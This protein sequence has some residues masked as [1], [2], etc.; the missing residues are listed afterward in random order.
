MREMPFDFAD[1]SLFGNDAGED[2]L[3]QILNSYFVEQPAFAPFLSRAQNFRI[4]RSRKGMGKSALLSK[5]A[6]DLRQLPDP[7]IVVKTTG[8]ELIGIAPP[9][10][11][12]NPLV[13]HN[14]WIGVL[15]ARINYAIGT[16]IGFAFS[17]T[18]MALVE[19]SEI[20]GFKSRNF[21]GALMARIKSSKIPI[22]ITTQEYSNHEEL[23]RRAFSEIPGRQVWLMVD[24]IDATFVNSPDH[25]SLVSSFFSAC[26]SIVPQVEG[27]GIR[28]SVRSDVWTAL[29]KN[30]ALDKCEQYCTE[31]Q[32]SPAE[33]KA[34]LARKILAY[35]ERKGTGHDELA[36]IGGSGLDSAISAVFERL[37]WDRALVPPFRPLQILSAGRPRW[38][39]QLCRLAGM[40]AAMHRRPR[41]GMSEIKAVLPEYSRLRL[42]DI[43][44]E[45]DHRFDRLQQL[46]ETFANG[47]ARYV[48]A[49]L[50]ELIES[51]FL[52][53]LPEPD[54]AEVDGQRLHSPLQLAHFLYKTGFLVGRVASGQPSRGSSEFV[55]YE[56]R[57]ELLDDKRNL[58]DGLDW[59]IHPSYREA[60][61]IGRRQAA[62]HPP[63][64][65]ML[66]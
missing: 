51:E 34:V 16:E 14:Y 30:E 23:F 39:S 27:L 25:N 57:P 11:S 20:A 35:L 29:R 21:V 22:E 62:R 52:P 8:A 17:D 53:V 56:H 36:R 41:I 44:K 15:C 12:T 2:E 37:R 48:T 66:P 33:L 13:L 49:N 1:G 58:D 26:R 55:R 5:F 6:Y 60:L 47:P 31:L 40:Q 63:V 50:L 9:P 65:A 64:P 42:S 38:L 4:A 28:A 10:Q 7:P 59:E 43:Y 3:P 32:W 24:D 46:I 18:S 61:N 45:H 54:C 19:S